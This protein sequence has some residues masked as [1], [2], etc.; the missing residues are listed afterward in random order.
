MAAEEGETRNPAV[1]AKTIAYLFLL[2][3]T[4]IY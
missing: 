2:F 4:F 1:E 3:L